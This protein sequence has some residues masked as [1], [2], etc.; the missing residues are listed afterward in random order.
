MKALIEEKQGESQCRDCRTKTEIA[1]DMLAWGFETANIVFVGQ[2]SRGYGQ[3]AARNK[4]EELRG[5]YSPRRSQARLQR[6]PGGGTPE[7]RWPPLS[8]GPW[9]RR[10]ASC[11][12]P[13]HGCSGLQI[14]VIP[15][16]EPTPAVHCAN[17]RARYG[18]WSASPLAKAKSQ[19]LHSHTFCSQRPNPRAGPPLEC[20]F[21]EF[22]ILYSNATGSI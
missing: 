2:F 1:K 11:R 15:Q 9:Q 21:S 4:S 3:M 13:A 5:R 20:A 10:W 14:Q 22:N 16:P 8:H 12:D 19:I 7:W 6:W 18:W 17:G